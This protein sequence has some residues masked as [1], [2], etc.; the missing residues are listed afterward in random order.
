MRHMK[1]DIVHDDIPDET[2]II[3]V[4]VILGILALVAIPV[5][6]SGMVTST[7]TGICCGFGALH[8]GKR[9]ANISFILQETKIGVDI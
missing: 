4:L 5:V 8:I 9:L 1:R 2:P 3:C 7:I 6:E